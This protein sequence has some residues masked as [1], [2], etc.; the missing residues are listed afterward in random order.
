MKEMWRCERLRAR[1]LALSLIGLFATLSLAGCYRISRPKDLASVA[2]SLSRTYCMGFCPVY[3]VT[4]HGNGLVE[5]FG[6]AGVPVR[7]ARTATVSPAT[8]TTLLEEIERA[9]FMSMRPDKFAKLSD[10]GEVTVS[11]LVDGKRTTVTSSQIEGAALTADNLRKHFRPRDQAEFAI[12]AD[13]I[14]GII[15]T[16]RWTECSRSCEEILMFKTLVDSRDSEGATILLQTIQSKRL[17]SLGSHPCDAHV[18]VEAGVDV[19]APNVRGFT[20]LMAAAKNDDAAL[21]RDLLA[22]GADP[23]AKD[24]KGLSALAYARSAQMRA[25]LSPE[26]SAQ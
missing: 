9:K 26:V 7:G 17:F 1:R 12:L 2:I 19:N 10:G 11:V 4:V 3:S 15:G 6:T 18:L 8:V 20:P 5:Y 14:D 21:V 23:A 13:R 25:L 24:Q 16:D 22:H